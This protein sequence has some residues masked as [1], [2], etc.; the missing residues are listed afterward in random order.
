MLLRFGSQE[1]I[2]RVM[3]D[4]VSGDIQQGEED[5]RDYQA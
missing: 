2:V 4:E 5:H 1:R 3:G